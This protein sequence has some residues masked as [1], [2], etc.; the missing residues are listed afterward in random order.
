MNSNFQIL[1]LCV[2][3]F[4][5][6]QP[7]L[8]QT[9]TME[10]TFKI[11]GKTKL[12]DTADPTVVCTVEYDSISADHLVIAAFSKDGNMISKIS[13]Q[14]T[15]KNFK[16]EEKDKYLLNNKLVADGVTQLF[17]SN[18][19][20]EAD[21]VYKDGK[22]V[23]ITS[24]YKNGNKQ[25]LLS[26]DDKTLNGSY[27]IWFANGRLNLVGNYIN[28]EKDDLFQ[29]FD[30]SEKLIKEGYYEKGS[31]VSGEAVVA[32]VLYDDPNMKAKFKDGL[33]AFSEELKKRS[34]GMES[35]KKLDDSFNKFFNLRLDIEKQGIV[36]NVDIISQAYDSEI[37]IIKS[38]FS[39]F[40][41]FLPGKEEGVPVSSSLYIEVMLNADGV[42]LAYGENDTINELVYF[43]VEE[44]PEFPGG[45]MAMRKHIAN[46]IRY[47]V[48]AQENGI[49]G[50]VYV[51][52]IVEKDGSTNTFR[53]VRG[54]HPL[55]DEEAIR[56]LKT[57]PR[58][59][60]GKQ[61]GEPVRISYTVPISFFLQ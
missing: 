12:P 13:C 39:D 37:K 52:F 46:N 55:L 5:C 23:E 51:Y 16:L 29:L 17:T 18:N 38:I 8:G 4:F 24:Y 56:V 50:K 28:N 30:E 2:S 7:S 45:E 14:F 25:M 26:G 48:L 31:L 6:I 47:P 53:V 57:M 40:S 20:L 61:K 11:I 59:K 44:M 49:Q 32:D 27:K 21:L 10:H 22:I 41:G 1:I 42:K 19:I 15:G 36:S 3:L 43:L 34:V 9:S 58:W 33:A 35:V 60:P 54:A